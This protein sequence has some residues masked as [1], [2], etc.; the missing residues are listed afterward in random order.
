M[1]P[2][3]SL[4]S[5]LNRIHLNKDDTPEEQSSDTMPVTRSAA[6]KPL[7]VTL[8]DAAEQTAPL[9]TLPPEIFIDNIIPLLSSDDIMSLSRTSKLLYSFCV[10]FAAYLLQAHTYRKTHRYGAPRWAPT[11]PSSPSRL[12]SEAVRTTLDGMSACTSASR[13]R[14]RTSGARPARRVSEALV[15]L[16]HARVPP[17]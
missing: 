1:S 7:V 16:L 14:G 11:S 9:F 13:S 5:L 3:S 4:S 12:L 8:D 6:K 17:V 2:Q 15:T 10:S